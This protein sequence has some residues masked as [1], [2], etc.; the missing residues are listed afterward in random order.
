MRR[1]CGLSVVA[2]LMLLIVMSACNLPSDTLSPSVAA[3]MVAATL[4]GLQTAA[5]A[6][7]TSMATTAAL[8]TVTANP[9]LTNTPA[10]SATPQNPLVT[11]LSLCWTGPGDAY[12]VVSSVKD[13]T[14]VELMGVGS[15]AGWYIIR[16]PRYNDPCW[17]EAK[18]LEID[19][20]FDLSSLRIYNPPPTPGPTETPVPVPTDTP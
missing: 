13:G 6:S 5:A 16:N 20:N 17:I 7:E 1:L 9:A 15:I 14:R 18:Y 2:G 4:S 12:P 19:P 11:Q 8:T 3:T 10:A